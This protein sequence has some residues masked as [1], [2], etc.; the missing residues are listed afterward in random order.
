MIQ[1]GIASLEEQMNN[2][3]DFILSNLPLLIPLLLLQLGL[4]IF[5]L[6]DLVRRERT[7]GP[8]WLWAIII[9]IGEL[10]GS[11]V[12]LLFGREE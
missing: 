8:K 6:I 1:Y 11:I 2:A 4:Q 3:M 5:S 7:K 12:Y 10:L 9:V